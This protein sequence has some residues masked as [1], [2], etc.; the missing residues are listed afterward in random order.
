MCAQR[1]ENGHG[2]YMV[3]PSAK[4]L[5]TPLSGHYGRRDT[6][7]RVH[8]RIAFTH[9]ISKSHSAEPGTLSRIA[10]PQ[11]DR[12]APAFVQDMMCGQSEPPPTTH[13]T[14]S[15]CVQI[16]GSVPRAAMPGRVTAISQTHHTNTEHAQHHPSP[17][18]RALLAPPATSRNVTHR[19]HPARFERARLDPARTTHIAPVSGAQ[20]S[21]Q[22][23]GTQ[24]FTTHR[25]PRRNQTRV[26]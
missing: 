11:Q 2:L 7:T 20:E 15:P 24:E 26:P 22:P 16:F 25:H 19:L 4:S 6:H 10:T 12:H 14:R 17:R 8:T 5:R 21:V 23:V 18:L 9:S 13:I 1:T 3:C